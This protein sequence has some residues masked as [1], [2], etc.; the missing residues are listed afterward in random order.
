[1]SIGAY[2]VYT[3]ESGSIPEPTWDD[4]PT[5]QEMLEIAF[6]DKFIDTYDHPVLKKLRGEI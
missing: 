3:A 5:M 6:R 1:M 2:E 4:L